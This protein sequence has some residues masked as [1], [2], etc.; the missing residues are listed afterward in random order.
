M[1]KKTGIGKETWADLEKRI[2]LKRAQG[3]NCRKSFGKVPGDILV[4]RMSTL[5][6]GRMKKYEPMDTR[7]FVP[8]ACKYDELNI[9]NIKT[10]CESFYNAPAGSCDILASDRGPSCS[11]MEQ[12]KGK[13]VYLIRFVQPIGTV[14]EVDFK[15][16]WR[17]YKKH[18]MKSPAASS[19]SS[20]GAI[21]ECIG[22]TSVVS[23][24]SVSVADL[25]KAGK[26]VKPLQQERVILHLEE[27]DI[28]LRSWNEAAS[29]EFMIDELKF[30]HG[31]FRDAHNA[32]AQSSKL[33]S[34]KWVVKKYQN[35][36]IKAIT[37]DLHI[38]I[39]DHTRKQVQLHAVARSMAK[40]FSRRVPVQFGETF[41]YRKTYYSTFK[42]LPIT[43]EEFVEGKF[44][45]YI[46]N[47]GKVNLNPAD[48][49]EEEIFAKAECFAHFT[50][51]MSDKKLMLLDI[52]GSGFTLY[53]P[54]IATETLCDDSGELYFCAG[55]TSSFGIKKF[56]EEHICNKYCDMLD[57]SE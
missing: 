44:I 45:K 52:Q 53:D 28:E 13:K 10:A 19:S 48:K 30:A 23:P 9:E 25:L 37:D 26:L 35:G 3:I 17:E 31:G 42:D 12:V 27:F 46:N 16:E 49:N 38:S 6:S 34:R 41:H 39:E 15:P 2:G 54:E 57:I 33:P 47:D 40:Q 5:P 55:N 1:N 18:C 50:Y 21:T 4:Q 8:F 43:V 24:K 36:A 32:Y 22:E 51:V 11:T 29:V 7:D 14:P 20:V 56:F